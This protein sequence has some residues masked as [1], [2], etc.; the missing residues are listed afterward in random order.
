VTKPPWPGSEPGSAPTS[1]ADPA[2]PAGAS[3][4]GRERRPDEPRSPERPPQESSAR[5]RSPWQTAFFVVVA[6]GVIAVIGWLVLAPKLLVVRSVVVSGNHLVS[7]SQVRAAA[8]IAPKTQML[9][10]D[11]SAAASRIEGI[12]QIQ[13]ATVSKS[14]PS[15][16]VIT[17][18][19]RT[20]A[21]AVASGL[22]PGTEADGYDLIDKAGVVVRSVKTRP[23]GMAVFQTSTAASSLR[24][25]PAVGAAVTVLHELPA[26]LARAV[27]TVS[28]ADAA[29]VRIG[30]A[31]GVTIVWGDT[32]RAQ[33]KST[34]ITVLM[35]TTHVSYYDVS[36]PGSAVTK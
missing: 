31:S 19:E 33:Q 15:R 34:E 18:H 36:A 32:S 2:A 4:P 6:V 21:L 26:S 7:V 23:A 25:N 29:D 13:S 12:N 17:V 8:D 5:S 28:A 11:T 22:A 16:I 1:V 10:V 3:A 35:Q 9:H 20:P 14:W 24:G 30:L 27:S